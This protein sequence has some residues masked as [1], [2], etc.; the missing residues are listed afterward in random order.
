MDEARKYWLEYEEI[1]LRSVLRER[2][3]QEEERR[4]LEEEAR[5]AAEEKRR[6]ELKAR[7]ENPDVNWEE[8]EI[9]RGRERRW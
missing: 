6:L 8:E 3:M 1:S 2:R 5:K 7:L 9:Y 4:Y